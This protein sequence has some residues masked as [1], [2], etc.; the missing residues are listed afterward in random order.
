MTGRAA[1][2]IRVRESKGRTAN[3][4]SQKLGPGGVL[5]NQNIYL[6]IMNEAPRTHGQK[7][8][9]DL[10]NGRPTIVGAYGHVEPITRGR[11]VRV[12]IMEDHANKAS[13]SPSPTNL[14]VDERHG[15]GAL[16][17]RWGLH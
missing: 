11:S 10:Q 5:G 16:M 14:E 9:R 15:M 1:R 8:M 2:S 12:K 6:T 3:Q 4:D 7:S 17:A 13:P